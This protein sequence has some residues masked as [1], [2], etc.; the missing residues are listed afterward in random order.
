MK[1]LTKNELQGI[2]S[3]S[4]TIKKW[5]EFFKTALPNLGY[6]DFLLKNMYPYEQGIPMLDGTYMPVPKDTGR[7]FFKMSFADK[8]AGALIPSGEGTAASWLRACALIFSLFIY[9]YEIFQALF[10]DKSEEDYDKLVE[11]FRIRKEDITNEKEVITRVREGIHYDLKKD[12]VPFTYWSEFINNSDIFYSALHSRGYKVIQGTINDLERENIPYLPGPDSVEFAG[13][14]FGSIYHLTG[15][16]PALFIYN[17]KLEDLSLDFPRDFMRKAMKIIS[18]DNAYSQLTRFDEVYLQDYLVISLNPIDKFMC[19]TKQAFSSC[20]SIARQDDISGTASNPAFGLPA[21]FPSDSVF[22]VFMTPGKHKNMYWE[23]S[24]WKKDPSERDKNKAYKYLKMTC[25]AL[26]YKGTLTKYAKGELELIDNSSSRFSD[27]KD[28]VKQCIKDINPTQARLFVGRQYSAKGEDFIWQ[29]LI[30]WLLSK[31]GISTAVAYTDPVAKL[32]S[33]TMT[34]PSLFAGIHSGLREKW[35]HDFLR[36]GALCD[37]KA[38]VCDRFGYV[39]GIY[40]D[41]VSWSW[42][43][44]AISSGK[45]ADPSIE[46]PANPPER[47]ENLIVVGS[48]RRGS[49]GVQNMPAKPGLDMFKMMLGIQDYSYL[50]A[51]VKICHECGALVPDSKQ[52]C[53]KG[54]YYCDACIA[55]KQLKRCEA[56]GEVYSTISQED[57]EAHRLYNVWEFLDPENVEKHA[58]NIKCREQLKYYDMENVGIPAYQLKGFCIHCGGDVRGSNNSLK[59]MNRSIDVEGMK[60]LVRLCDKCLE[61]AVMCDKCRHVVF[62]EEETKPVILLPGKRVVCPRCIDSIRAKKEDK[63]LLKEAIQKVKDSGAFTP[64]ELSDIDS[65]TLMAYMERE[66]AGDTGRLNSVTKNIY[67]QIASYLQGNPD[68]SFPKIAQEDK[69]PSSETIVSEETADTGAESVLA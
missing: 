38:T 25:R 12:S 7:V 21:L 24:E 18:G 41:N 28:T 68:R 27:I 29:A 31:Q 37:N 19:S 2:D 65:K 14:R 9:K 43:P 64:E 53:Y 56:C 67:K 5:D 66:E 48:S 40:Y 17:K 59:Y 52:G 69:T 46:Y 20:I 47:G 10:P 51:N 33:T 44:G 13:T 26:T 39:R 8:L 1:L 35:Y 45:V 61:R 63:D 62:L 30:E 58:P 6:K 22:M 32:Q 49:C 15:S 57:L 55:K 34:E 3:T 36:E 60:I 16:A 11:Y 42:R 4:T 23:S 50:N 54:H